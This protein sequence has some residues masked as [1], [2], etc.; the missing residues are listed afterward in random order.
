MKLRDILDGDCSN[1][2]ILKEG[3]YKGGW[4]S[5]GNGNP[6]EPPC[7]GIG[8][9]EE[10][11]E[12]IEHYYDSVRRHE[13]FLERKWEEEQKR[14]RKNEIIRRKRLYSNA[15]CAAE[16]AEVKL[17]KKRIRSEEKVLSLADSIVSAFNA[18]NEVFGYSERKRINPIAKAEIE[19]LKNQLKDA[20]NR[21]K[22]KR[23]ECRKTEKYKN[24][25]KEVQK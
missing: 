15:Y 7:T 12:W 6:I 8:E 23:K 4:T 14:K 9:E 16:R 1:C 2:P 17:L 5:D 13:E 19:N 20:E 3:I 11:E 10:L 25:G 22:K 24:I 21:L 18:T